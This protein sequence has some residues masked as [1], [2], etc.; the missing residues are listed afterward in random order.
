MLEVTESEALNAQRRERILR[1][2]RFVEARDVTCWEKGAAGFTL[3]SAFP[4][5]R[6][7][8]AMDDSF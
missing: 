6:S 4:S 8:G 7:P 5:R 1:A 3:E 2:E